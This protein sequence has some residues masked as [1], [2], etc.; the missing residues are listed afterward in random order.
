MLADAFNCV[1]LSAVPTLTAAGVLQVI[2]GVALLTVIEFDFVPDKTLVVLVG[3]KL[4]ER[5]CV[6]AVNTVP[7]VG[8]YVNVP[9]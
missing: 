8:V 3:V 6:P 7:A 9:G 1:A 4:T 2:V 5:E